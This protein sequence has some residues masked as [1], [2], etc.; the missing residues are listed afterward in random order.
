MS[1]IFV[2]HLHDGKYPIIWIDN[3]NAQVPLEDELYGL[4]RKSSN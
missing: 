4:V 3:K 1:F 2:R